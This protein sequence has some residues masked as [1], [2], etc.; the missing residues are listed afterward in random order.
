MSAQDFTRHPLVN[1]DTRGNHEHH[2]PVSRRHRCRNGRYHPRQRLAPGRNRL[3]PGPAAG[4]P[5]H[6]R[7]R[8]PPLRRGRRPALRLR[9]RRRRLARRG[10]G[11]GHRYRL[12][13]GGQRPAPRDRRGP[14]QGRQARP[15]REAPGGHARV[16]PRHGAGREGGRRRHRRRIHLPPQRRRGRARQARRRGPPG[17]DQPLRRPLLVRLRRRPL[18]PHG[19]ALQGPHGLGGPGRRRQ[20]P[21]RYRRAHLWPHHLG[22]G[23]SHD[24][25]HQGAPRDRW[26][27]HSRHR[28]GRRRLR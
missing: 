12:H 13:R 3:R 6:H 19:L 4:P 17:R 18:H 9:A 14:H 2:S 26:T 24:D 23:R 22:L 20:S 5:A 28:S 7:R 25:L 16:R 11:P 21:H 15:V 1:E 10:R 8:L 27:R